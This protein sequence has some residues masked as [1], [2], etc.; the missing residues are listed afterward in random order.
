MEASKGNPEK[1]HMM[2]FNRRRFL[3]GA[4]FAPVVLAA[5]GLL[6]FGNVAIAQEAAAPAAPTFLRRKVGDIEVFALFDGHIAFPTAFLGGFDPVIA[7]AAARAAHKPVDAEMMT[8]GINAYLIRTKDRI[9]AVDAGAPAVMGPT[10]AGWTRSLAAA[11]FAPEDVD[12]VFLTHLH[13]DHV[14]GLSDMATGTP[15]LP[16]AQIVASEV[17]WDFTHDSA[18]Y[19][20]LSKDLQGFFDVS[21]AM[22][23]PYEAGKTLIAAGHEIAPGLTSVAMPGHTPDHLGLRIDSGNESLL[24]WG[25]ALHSTAHQFARPDWTFAFDTDADAAAKTRTAALDM[26]ATDGLMVAGMHLDFPGFGY[27]EKAGEGYR[28]IPAP[29]DYRA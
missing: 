3:S 9:I 13:P 18:V 29:H 10:V 25:D 20:A 15:F 23:A 2:T 28:F 27:V 6:R 12:T 16:K 22:V 24:I 26:A 7:E 19:A 21:R 4:A 11:G 14:G 17:D 5:P 1:D 8:L